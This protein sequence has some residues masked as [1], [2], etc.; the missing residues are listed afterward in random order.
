MLPLII[1]TIVCAITYSFEIIFGLAGTILM[2][3]VL[4]LFFDTKTVVIYSILPQMLVGI[5]ALTKTPK[6]DWEFFSKMLVTAFCGGLVGLYFFQILALDVFEKL[7]GLMIS[8]AGL[9][10]VVKPKVSLKPAIQKVLDFFA[11]I[12]HALFSISGPIVV[13]RLSSTFSNKTEIRNHA[14]MFFFSLNFVR[15]GGFISNQ[16][17]TPEIIQMFY[18]SAPV[19]IITLFFADK[20]HFKLNDEFFKKVVSWVILLS[21]V[22]ILF[23]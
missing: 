4:V 14:L 21:G 7:L 23:K 9:F 13:T 10:L 5:I 6:I 19:L 17:F 8:S 2:M 11:G 15:L 18:V 12:S 16:S 3:P 22:F 1:L 20:L